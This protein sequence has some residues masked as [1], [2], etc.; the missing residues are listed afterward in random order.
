MWFSKMDRKVSCMKSMKLSIIENQ[1][2]YSRSQIFRVIK[3]QERN[4]LFYAYMY[5]VFLHTFSVSSVIFH[6]KLI[7]Y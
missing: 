5:S 6:K 2:E 7:T 4:H 3:L 1:I